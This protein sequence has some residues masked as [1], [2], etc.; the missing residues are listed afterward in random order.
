MVFRTKRTEKMFISL[1]TVLVGSYFLLALF[2][3]LTIVGVTSHVSSSIIKEKE[4]KA[5]MN[6]LLHMEERMNALMQ[7]YSDIML[8]LIYDKNT[9]ALLH[10]LESLTEEQRLSLA[11]TLNDAMSEASII[12]TEI[13]SIYFMDKFNNTY[14]YDFSLYSRDDILSHYEVSGWYEEVAERKGGLFVDYSG[15]ILRNSDL[16]TLA[17]SIVR[18]NKEIGVLLLNIKKEALLALASDNR[19]D[20]IMLL[21]QQQQL[22]LDW[23]ESN[24]HANAHIEYLK[25][26]GLQ[27]SWE[28]EVNGQPYLATYLKNGKY[29]YT[30]LSMVSEKEL[31]K[32]AAYIYKV[33]VITVVFILTSVA[34]LSY[35][36]SQ[37]LVRP[38]HKLVQL[39]RR[40]EQG[41]LNIGMKRIPGNELGI[42]AHQFNRMVA[43]LKES[44]PLRRERF[45]GKLLFVQ[46]T[47]QEYGEESLQ[48]GIQ[49]EAKDNYTV[50]FELSGTVK[51]AAPGI[52]KVEKVL[53]ELADTLGEEVY[54]YAFDDRRVIMI[55]VLPSN[56]GREEQ[57]G[58]LLTQL[59]GQLAM[60]MNIGAGSVGSGYEHVRHSYQ[61]A[62]SALNYAF[63]YGENE[64]IYWESIE[65][66]DYTYEMLEQLEDEIADA[67]QYT[68]KNR[69]ETG[70]KQLFDV[71][72]KQSIKKEVVT[73][74]VSHLYMKCMKKVAG[75]GGNGEEGMMDKLRFM[76]QIQERV[77]LDALQIELLRMLTA[78]LDDIYAG[79]KKGMNE[80]VVRAMKAI[81]ERYG[82]SGLTL[83]KL[84]AELFVSENYLSKLFKK[85]TGQNFSQHLLKQ[86]MERAKELLKTTDWKV[87]DISDQVGYNDANYFS[88]CFKALMGGSPAKYRDVCRNSDAEGSLG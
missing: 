82:D 78:M 19:F 36:L 62:S 31:L 41:D 18:G 2:I 55:A 29:G 7:K 56:V 20:N 35:F 70:V 10:D 66:R 38:V 58:G 88:T 64:I 22:F 77:T 61:Q 76:E 32:D 15:T 27:G 17:R 5:V 16:I 51:D 54:I 21:D 65:Q 52:R 23:N 43:L 84:A 9:Q 80:V 24:D 75:I 86:R 83:G 30:L 67:L 57:L 81:E 47:E 40:V 68:E 25:H 26:A 71:Y 87:S 53:A 72:R 50:I 11:S 49:L 1:K 13:G 85:E 63:I 59:S 4:S 6:Q 37:S 60:P 39:M 69:L 44:M 3:L 42:L 8:S 34:L 48:L 28:P 46:L 73:F 79:R 33:T 74:S 14:A 12:T 45:L